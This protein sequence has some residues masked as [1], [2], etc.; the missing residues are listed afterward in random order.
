[1]STI[2]FESWIDGGLERVKDFATEAMEFEMQGDN[3]ASVITGS[4]GNYNIAKNN[5]TRLMQVSIIV[6]TGTDY[7]KY[8]QNIINSNYAAYANPTARRVS[9]VGSARSVSFDVVN[10]APSSFS[11]SANNVANAGGGTKS[12]LI[13]VVPITGFDVI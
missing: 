9:V 8:L 1:M 4:F 2:S 6:L 7:D 3:F 10:I 11:L 12:Y 13:Q 5:S